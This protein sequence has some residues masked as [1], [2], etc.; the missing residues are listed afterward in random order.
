MVSLFPLKKFHPSTAYLV[1]KVS[2]DLLADKVPYEIPFHK[3][4]MVTTKGRLLPFLT[5]TRKIYWAT[6]NDRHLE[7]KEKRA[8]L[9][10]ASKKR[11]LALIIK[12]HIRAMCYREEVHNSKKKKNLIQHHITINLP[13]KLPIL[14]IAYPLSWKRFQ[15]SKSFSSPNFSLILQT[16]WRHLTLSFKSALF[17]LQA[18]SNSYAHVT[19][20]STAIYITV[21]WYICFVGWITRAVYKNRAGLHI[22]IC[23]L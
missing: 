2:R 18:Y 22:A 5:I 1:K 6:V 15:A 3:I 16:L 13:P 11:Q 23:I 9:F 20:N 21:W 12:G 19:N 17:V 4:H 7:L 10:E 14:Y 8:K